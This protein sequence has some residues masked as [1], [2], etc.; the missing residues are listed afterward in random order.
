[1]LAFRSH[2]KNLRE[3]L[4]DHK[5]AALGDAYVNF[6]Y[7]LALS[8]RKGQPVGI[9]VGSQILAEALKRA[10]LRKL[11]PQR[12]DRHDRADALEAMIVYAWM[13]DVV[14][15][16]EGVDLLVEYEDPI[17]AFCALTCTIRKRLK[18]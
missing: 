15:I 3:V 14:G 4:L 16:Q 8:K 7:S 17:E 10:G 11:L 13:Q 9:K 18:L 6:I 12:M 1:M 5:L 2:Y